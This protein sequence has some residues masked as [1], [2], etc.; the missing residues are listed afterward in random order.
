MRTIIVH[1]P[2]SVGHTVDDVKATVI[3][4]NLGILTE[5][6]FPGTVPFISVKELIGDPNYGMSDHI[7]AM[8]FEAGVLTRTP[9]LDD[10]GRQSKIKLDK[11]KEELLWDYQWSEASLHELSLEKLY[12]LAWDLRQHPNFCHV[13]VMNEVEETVQTSQDSLDGEEPE[14]YGSPT[15]GNDF[16]SDVTP[17]Y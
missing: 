7:C 5:K 3:E 8:L 11:D 9:V 2:I 16:D 12:D 4:L 14:E 6:E 15:D 13:S 17:A 1:N 10:N